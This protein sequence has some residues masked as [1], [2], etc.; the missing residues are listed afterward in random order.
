MP[1]DKKKNRQSKSERSDESYNYDM[2]ST[3]EP[4][5]SEGDFC[6]VL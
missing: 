5:P 4:V 3:K 6:F 2:E 1:S